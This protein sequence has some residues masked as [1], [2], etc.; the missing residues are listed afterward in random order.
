MTP[1]VLMANLGRHAPEV[2]LDV[3]W[4]RDPYYSW[5]GD[6]PDPADDGYLAHDVTASARAIIGSATPIHFSGSSCMGGCYDK[7]GALCPDI[8]GYLPQMLLEAV[9]EL[10]DEVA[11]QRPAADVTLEQDELR[12]QGDY[13]KV[14]AD[15][16][17]AISILRREMRDRYHEQFPEAEH[18]DSL[19]AWQELLDAYG[20]S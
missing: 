16:D 18:E 13:D 5:D 19:K 4:D 10:R 7:P 17:A 14:M 11:R 3:T 20:Q 15:C 8:H 6:G 9:E 1:E 12:I 2:R